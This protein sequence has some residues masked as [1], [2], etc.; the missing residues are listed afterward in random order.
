MSGISKF[1]GFPPAGPLSW[2]LDKRP[3]W[4]GGSP[5][6]DE[7]GPHLGWWHAKAALALD[8]F[9]ERMM[10][11]GEELPLASV[12]A[13]LRSS[14]HLLADTQ[15]IHH[16]FAANELATIAGRG[17]YI[18]GQMTPLVVRNSDLLVGWSNSS[19]PLTHSDAGGMALGIFTRTLLVSSDAT[20]TRHRRITLPN[21]V[22]S[23]DTYT[24][25]AHYQLGTS[26]NIL[27]FLENQSGGTF[28]RVAGNVAAPIVT[29]MDAG[30]ISNLATVLLPDG[31]TY[32][33]TFHWVPNFS[34]IPR[35]GMGPYNTSPSGGTVI[36]LGMD[37]HPGRLATPWI[38]SEGS[39]TMT[40]SR[41]A[42]DVRVMASGSE[43]FDGYDAA[44]LAS[45]NTVLFEMSL[46]ELASG[47]NRHLLNIAGGSGEHQAVYLDGVTNE[48]RIATKKGGAMP[49]TI[50]VPM[51]AAG[52]VRV[53][54]RFVDG[55]YRLRRSGGG[56]SVG[57]S[58]VTGAM[59]SPLTTIHLGQA[60]NLSGHLNGIVKQ[61]Q[62]CRPLTDSE[63][64][65]WV[66]A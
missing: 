28:S 60:D 33:T 1:S 44:G 31:V 29:T 55:S 10:R 6:S 61:V 54:A 63:M 24:V 22:K 17:A 18:G 43:P 52:N 45:G 53:A 41:L 7:Q 20:N 9:N 13:T 27:V 14:A 46:S 51:V 2:P 3:V 30:A 34:D 5:D 32:R 40:T 56:V 19:A 64:D 26:G 50:G 65:S 58:A 47:T 39:S 11:G 62:I 48:L 4:R 42:S 59:P 21:A 57:T 23:G 35:V 37:I 38:V 8:F 16:S 66:A 25:I 36:A 12:V 49:F 15:G